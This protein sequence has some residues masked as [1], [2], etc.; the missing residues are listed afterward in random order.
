MLE[1]SLAPFLH[2]YELWPGSWYSQA[3]SSW[4]VAW[5]WSE[6]VLVGFGWVEGDHC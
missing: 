4:L 3:V 6:G 5:A 2:I 1:G